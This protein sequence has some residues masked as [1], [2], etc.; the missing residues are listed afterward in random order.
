[1]RHG[2]D[3]DSERGQQ[4]LRGFSWRYSRTN[5]RFNLKMGDSSIA[6]PRQAGREVDARSGRY[7]I[8]LS[9]RAPRRRRSQVL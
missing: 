9:V 5:F 3:A 8:Y 4:A 6:N 7:H 1:M 2:R